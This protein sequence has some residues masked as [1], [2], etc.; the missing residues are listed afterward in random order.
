MIDFKPK[1]DSFYFLFYLI[2]LLFYFF[3]KSNRKNNKISDEKKEWN[4][5]EEGKKR[6][7]WMK[8]KMKFGSRQYKLKVWNL[9]KLWS[10]LINQIKSLIK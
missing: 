5:K 3:I 2:L 6:M 8:N 10:S 1:F 7:K 4:E 9:I